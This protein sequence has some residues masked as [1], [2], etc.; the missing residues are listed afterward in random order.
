M[1]VIGETFNE[2]MGKDVPSTVIWN[3]LDDM[4]DMDTLNENNSPP[5]ELMEDTDFDLP[6]DFEELLERKRETM[7]SEEQSASNDSCSEK[8]APSTP[9]SAPRSQSQS[10]SKSQ[11]LLKPTD[12]S[13]FK[14]IKTYSNE[15]A[16]SDVSKKEEK[17]GKKTEEVK[18]KDSKSDTETPKAKKPSRSSIKSGPSTETSS[19]SKTTSAST[20]K[21]RQRN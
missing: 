19:A 8:G 16:S 2:L 1:V 3:H 18:E 9:T 14:G 4:Y 7:S 21:K 12:S 17:T 11:S 20:Q 5:P 15:S 10:S 6:P 13:K